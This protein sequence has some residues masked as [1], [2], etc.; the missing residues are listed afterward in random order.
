MIIRT[1]VCMACLAFALWVL[2][3]HAQQDEP[4]VLCLE[5]WQAGPAGLYSAADVERRTTVKL[6]KACRDQLVLY[7]LAGLDPDQRALCTFKVEYAS[8][9]S[10]EVEVGLDGLETDTGEIPSVTAELSRRVYAECLADDRFKQMHLSLCLKCVSG[11]D[12]DQG[13]QDELDKFLDY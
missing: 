3:A 9:S 4:V 8:G 1:A 10:R 5:T 12:H 11:L 7:E 13:F 6:P 2:P